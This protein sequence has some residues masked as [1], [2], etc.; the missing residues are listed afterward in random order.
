MAVMYA[1]NGKC[2]N[3]RDIKNAEE[4]NVS[5]KTW[6]EFICPIK[7][8]SYC[9]KDI[10]QD[11]FIY[12]RGDIDFA[13]CPK[14]AEGVITGLSRDLLELKG[15]GDLKGKPSSPCNPASMD[16]EIQRLRKKCLL[17]IKQIVHLQEILAKKED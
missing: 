8:C 2:I 6:L 14:C 4:Q 16:A 5:V 9:D 3:E 10:W 11:N 13:L 15:R 17:Y 12:W 1:K 7:K